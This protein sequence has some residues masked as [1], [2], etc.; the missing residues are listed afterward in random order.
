MK[1]KTLP[2]ELVRFLRHL[3][4]EWD[5]SGKP[6][7]QLAEKVGVSR[8][9]LINVRDGD[10][11]PGPGLEIAFAEIHFGGSIDEF[12]KAAKAWAATNPEHWRD[13]P[14]W[15][16]AAAEAVRRWPA[17]EIYIRGAGELP[18]GDRPATGPIDATFVRALAKYFKRTATTE[19]KAALVGQQSAERLQR[20]SQTM[21]I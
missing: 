1:R 17:W 11:G 14:G 9:Q 3:V 13:W 21:K 15:T 4:Q 2:Q 19:E 12:R 18:V 20:P 8:T 7:G 5:A 6:M 16:E 10:R